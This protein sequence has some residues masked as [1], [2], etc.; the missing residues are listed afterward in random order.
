MAKTFPYIIILILIFIIAVG[1]YKYD[2][3]EDDIG[4]DTLYL[5]VDSVTIIKEAT[6]GLW[7]GTQD[8]AIQKFGKVIKK[9]VK[10][11]RRIDSLVIDSVTVFDTVSVAVEYLSSMDSL[12]Y[13]GFNLL[14]EDTLKVESLIRVRTTAYLDPVNAIEN[15]I[16]V[17]DLT[18]IVP[19]RPRPSLKE[20][21]IEYWEWLVGIFLA[22]FLFGK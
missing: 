15:T 1:Y 19:P 3:S 21:A 6:K 7:I 11:T 12:R 16:S 10:Q 14:E 5:P 9:V 18:V 22:G 13:S 8:E 20:L 2:P 17:E 4:G